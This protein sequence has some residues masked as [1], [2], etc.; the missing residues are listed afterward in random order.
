MIRA[1]QIA[2]ARNPRAYLHLL[3]ILG[4]GSIEKR[5]F[6]AVI[7][8]GDVIFD[9]GA[10]LGYFTDLFSDITGRDG[11]V[12]AFEPLPATYSL[13][14]KRIRARSSGLNVTL[15]EAACGDV[16]GSAVLVVPAGDAQQASLAIHASGSWSQQGRASYRVQ[17]IRLDEYL[18]SSGSRRVD[19]LKCDA[20]GAE[21]AIFRGLGDQLERLKPLLCF[22]VCPNWTRDFG[23][24]SLEMITFLQRAGYDRLFA[25]SASIQ[26]VT[27]DEAVRVAETHQSVNVIAASSQTHR[28]RIAR[29]ISL[30][31]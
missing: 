7:R 12:H 1:L 21:L 4:R 6:L 22:E 29:L 2:L 25:L 13:L 24:S 5:A 20:E 11:R 3:S 27:P 23:Y 17:T 26:P 14:T 31:R 30:V 8:P 9:V 16:S 10:N 15:V 18:E 19:F 28:D